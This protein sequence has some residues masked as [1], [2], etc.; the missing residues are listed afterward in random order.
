MKKFMRRLRMWLTPAK[1][2]RHCCLWCE[3]ADKCEPLTFCES[4]SEWWWSVRYRLGL[5]KE[6]ID[7]V[8]VGMEEPN[9]NDE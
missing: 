7:F 2:C 3:Y 8:T 9:E 5:A 4:W 6:G 1:M